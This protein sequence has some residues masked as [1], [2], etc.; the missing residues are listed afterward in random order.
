[1][2][3]ESPNVHDSATTNVSTRTVSASTVAQ[4]VQVCTPGIGKSVQ[5]DLHGLKC[6]GALFIEG[7]DSMTKFYTGLPSWDVFEHV[8]SILISHVP[9]KWSANSKLQPR[10]ELLLVLVRLR[11]NLLLE[12]IAYRFGIAKSTVTTIINLWI[13]VMAMR[14]KFLIKWVPKEIVQDNMPQI[15]KETYPLT[16]CI[17]DCSE[18]FI[19]RPFAYEA[20]GKTYYKKH[21]TAKFLI[22]I[23]P[24]GSISFVSTVWGGRVSDKVITQRSGFL[25]LIEPGDTILA[26][27]GFTNFRGF[28]AIWGK[29]RDSIIHSRKITAE[30]KR[31]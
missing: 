5:T 12:D 2:N 6:F 19:E 10:D 29:T 23:S 22:A 21:N 4:C 3:V 11:L 14:L 27:R 1:M 26:D 30:P 15:F 8:Y 24:S 7:N 13:D 25:D 31:S 28:T 20:R 9:K 17:I 16:R 18:I